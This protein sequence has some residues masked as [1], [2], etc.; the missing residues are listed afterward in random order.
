MVKLVGVPRSNSGARIRTGG[1]KG[2]EF[3]LH[4]IKNAE[5]DAEI[6]GLHVDSLAIGHIQDN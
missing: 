4:M 2:A 1:P 6:K 3:L 5:T